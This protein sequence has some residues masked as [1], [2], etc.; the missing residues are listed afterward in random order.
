MFIIQQCKKTRQLFK[1]FLKKIK[2]KNFKQFKQIWHDLIHHH[3]THNLTHW[4]PERKTRSSSSGDMVTVMIPSGFDPKMCQ[5]W[6]MQWGIL[7]AEAAAASEPI[8]VCSK[9]DGPPRL[10]VCLAVGLLSWEKV[11]L[12]SRGCLNCLLLLGNAGPADDAVEILAR[13]RQIH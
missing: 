3:H 9:M 5:Q 6:S 4:L 12:V 8:N 1:T 2:L 10:D 7:S 13:M 11:G